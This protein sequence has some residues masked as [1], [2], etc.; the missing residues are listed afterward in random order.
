MTGFE[1]GEGVLGFPFL[2]I[3]APFPVVSAPVTLS[4]PVTP[5]T[6]GVHGATDPAALRMSVDASLRWHDDG[7][8]ASRRP[9]GKSEIVYPLNSRR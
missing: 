6:A 3:P 9:F 2:V 5:A 7:E 4:L 1:P 8:A